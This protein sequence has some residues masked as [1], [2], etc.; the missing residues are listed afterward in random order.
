MDDVTPNMILP[1]YFIFRY[2]LAVALAVIRGQRGNQKV[3]PVA[4]RSS[5]IY[6]IIQYKSADEQCLN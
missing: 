3:R 6:P 5:V 1:L 4:S 2:S